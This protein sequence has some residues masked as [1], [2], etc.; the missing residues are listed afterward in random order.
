MNLAWIFFVQNCVTEFNRSII[1]AWLISAFSP[2]GYVRANI[3]PDNFRYLFE[4]ALSYFTASSE[5]DF[6]RI[7]PDCMASLAQFK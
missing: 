4:G 3:Y 1:L 2:S 7:F 6:R 5:K